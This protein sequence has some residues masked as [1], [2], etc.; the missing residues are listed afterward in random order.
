ML[1]SS[2]N[3]LLEMDDD[4]MEA[5]RLLNSTESPTAMKASI[6]EHELFSHDFP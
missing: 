1:K 2:S 4:E 3:V 5:Q 6:Y